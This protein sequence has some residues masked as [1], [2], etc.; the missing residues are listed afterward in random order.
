[1]DAKSE[2]LDIPHSTLQSTGVVSEATTQTMLMQG[3]KKLNVDV[4]VVS[5]GS[6]GPLPEK[7]SRVGEVYLGVAN[8]HNVLIK[9][10]FFQGDR[11]SIRHQS[12]R[13]MV[14]LLNE[15]LRTYY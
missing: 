1:M 11:D 4:V 9:P 3:L 5:T 2:W 8:Q 14:D 12:V 6:A 10:Y 7:N 13:A 15:F